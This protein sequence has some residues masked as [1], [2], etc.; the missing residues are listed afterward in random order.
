MGKKM[1]FSFLFKTTEEE[2]TTTITAAAL[3]SLEWPSCG[4]H[5][6]MNFT[7]DT[8]TELEDLGG[9]DSVES[10]ISGLRTVEQLFFEPRET[11]SILG[12]LKTTD[13]VQICPEKEDSSSSSRGGDGPK[14]VVVH[15]TI[16]K[17]LDIFISMG[18][19]NNWVDYIMREDAGPVGLIIDF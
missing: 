9:G 18:S 17:I 16:V 5:K 4:A 13:Q 15:E 7:Y 14:T 1:K 19:P 6:T 12:E 3:A 10:V 11:S 8:A 2:S